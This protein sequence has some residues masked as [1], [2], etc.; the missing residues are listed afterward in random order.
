MSA[1]AF[2]PT[3]GTQ[4][5]VVLFEFKASLVY[6]ASSRTARAMCSKILSLKKKK[7]KSL[8]SDITLKR[9]G[10]NKYRQ[11]ISAL[12]IHRPGKFKPVFSIYKTILGDFTHHLE[13]T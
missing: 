9:Q 3:L 5:L 11:T 12:Q 2:N 6:L 10:N 4:R 13:T 8:S 1:Q 7:K